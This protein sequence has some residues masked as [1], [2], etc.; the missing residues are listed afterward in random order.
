MM[1]DDNRVHVCHVVYSFG[2]GGL[3][4]VIANCILSLDSKKYRHSII[5]LT[6]VGDSTYDIDDSVKIYSLFKREGHDTTIHFKFFKLLRKLKPKVLHTYNLATIEYQWA[7]AL[8]NIPLRVHAEHGRDTY[9]VDGSI[10]KYKLLRKLSSLVVHRF[11]A[12]SQDLFDWLKHEVK[13][14]ESKLSLV[15]NGIDTQHYQPDHS[16]E[17]E[18]DFSSGKFV[19]WSHI[20]IA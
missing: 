20:K 13:I 16:L 15:V 2:I 18:I 12:V 14:P 4:R 5:A 3:E 7:G 1:K 6:S 8:A 11:I 17:E 19:F 10:S 9:D